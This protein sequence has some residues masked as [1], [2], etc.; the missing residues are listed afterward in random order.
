MS[1]LLIVQVALVFSG[2]TRD[3]PVRVPAVQDQALAV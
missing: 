3:A 1:L 2:R